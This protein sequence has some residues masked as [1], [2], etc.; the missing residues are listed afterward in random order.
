VEESVDELIRKLEGKGKKIKIL[1]ASAGGPVAG[2]D[3]I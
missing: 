2:E 1:D 3:G